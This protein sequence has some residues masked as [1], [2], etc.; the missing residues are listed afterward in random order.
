MYKFLKSNDS[1]GRRRVED[2]SESNTAS[3]KF[4][5]EQ[6]INSGQDGWLQINKK[7]PT[8]LSVKS[9]SVCECVLFNAEN[10]RIMAPQSI[11]F[12]PAALN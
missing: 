10:E 2:A 4:W 5:T 1:N 8:L 6:N 12:I 7:S 11:G 9:V 3:A